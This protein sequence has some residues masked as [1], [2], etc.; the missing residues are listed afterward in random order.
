[1][2]RRAIASGRKQKF[3]PEYRALLANWTSIDINPTDSKQ[4]ILP[5]LWSFLFFYYHFTTA[6]ELT[7]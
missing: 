7:A 4:L 6:D 2:L 5:G 3:Y 1:L